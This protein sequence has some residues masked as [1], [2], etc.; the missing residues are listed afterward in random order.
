MTY[1]KLMN[2]F[3]NYNKAE[4][5]IENLD[6]EINDI[7]FDLYNLK[8]TTKLKIPSDFKKEYLEFVTDEKEKE[9]KKQ[10]LDKFINFKTNY[11]QVNIDVKRQQIIYTQNDADL[12]KTDD[13]SIK[14]VKGTDSRTPDQ[15]NI[16][17]KEFNII[18][19]KKKKF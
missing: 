11:P 5:K 1:K 17:N 7:F 6:Y 2:K 10:E 9:S 3:I 13:P 18:K 15:M 12:E 14:Y 16:E 19:N 8:N 4:N